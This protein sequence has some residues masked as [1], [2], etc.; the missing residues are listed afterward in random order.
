MMK[1]KNKLDELEYSLI[2]EG[3]IS[4]TSCIRPFKKKLFTD[5]AT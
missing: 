1:F 4:L 5:E 2:G 3:K